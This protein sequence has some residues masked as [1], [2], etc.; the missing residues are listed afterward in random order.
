[1]QISA[2]GRVKDH[3]DVAEEVGGGSW[4]YPPLAMAMAEA[5]LEEIGVY[6]TRRQNTVARYIATRS[7]QDLCERYVRRPGVWVSWRWW[8]QDGLDM[9][10]AKERAAAESD[11]EKG[12]SQEETKGRE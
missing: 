8:E 1:M 2:Q 5:G 6:V 3:Q 11:E 12:T 4:Y 10:G 7:I 9:E